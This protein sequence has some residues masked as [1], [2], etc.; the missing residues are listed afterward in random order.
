MTNKYR[1]LTPINSADPL[2]DF[3]DLSNKFVEIEK[4]TD[5]ITNALGAISESS[6]LNQK[7]QTSLRSLI[8][9]SNQSNKEF[10]RDLR[11][12]RSLSRKRKYLSVIT[13]EE[14]KIKDVVFEVQKKELTPDELMKE[15]MC[16]K[17]GKDWNLNSK[18]TE[19]EKRK[20]A[21]QIMKLE[22][23]IVRYRNYYGKN[24]LKWTP[25]ER[26]TL[27]AIYITL[28]KEY[29]KLGYEEGQQKNKLI[30]DNLLNNPLN[31]LKK[32]SIPSAPRGCAKASG[33]KTFCKFVDG[34]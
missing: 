9:E 5:R 23:I 17:L 13:E 27:S 22:S 29:E 16:Q 19:T 15:M 1:H 6:L 14:P 8:R 11:R 7:T 4:K 2:K 10:K 3:T 18:L 34:D 32:F 25:E 31:K 28:S 24:P 33:P 26:K 20:I 12:K 30:A 21:N